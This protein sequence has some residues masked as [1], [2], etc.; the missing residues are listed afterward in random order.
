MAICE[1]GLPSE[2]LKLILLNKKSYK[3][4]TVLQGM[5]VHIY[6]PYWSGCIYD[7]RE[8]WMP[9]MDCKMS[10][11]SINGVETAINKMM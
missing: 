2:E 9:V 6:F 3:L 11:C 8:D 5:K 1:M 7:F 4:M 10:N